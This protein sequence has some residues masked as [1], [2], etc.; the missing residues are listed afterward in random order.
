M[1][2]VPAQVP[3]KQ[4]VA[5]MQPE[6]PPV[7]TEETET[8]TETNQTDGVNT[9][10]RTRSGVG[11]ETGGSGD[12]EIRELTPPAKRT[13]K[14]KRIVLH[15]RLVS[16]GCSCGTDCAMAGYG[17]KDT[18]T[19][20]RGEGHV[21]MDYD[22]GVPNNGEPTTRLPESPSVEKQL[23]MFAALV[24]KKLDEKLGLV[25]KTTDIESLLTKVD[26][27]AADITRLR[28]SIDEVRSQNRQDK[29]DLRN[30]MK[31]YA[32]DLLRG[33]DGERERGRREPMEEVEENDIEDYPPIEEIRPRPANPRYKQT[34]VRFN[35]FET[36]TRKT[37]RAGARSEE[38]EASRIEKYN[39]ARRSVKVWPIAG[40]TKDEIT[41]N[42]TDFLHRCLGLSDAQ[43]DD[44]G[45][46]RVER[47]GLPDN[48]TVHNE[49]RIVLAS[50]TAR[51]FIFGQ[52]PK[53]ASYVTEDGKPTAGFRVD[54]P[55]Y[56]G[57]EWKL[58]DDLGFQ[59]KRENGPGTRKYIKH[60]D[61]NYGFFLEIRLPGAS[62][63]TKIS[64][65]IAQR[66]RREREREDFE[67]FS[68]ARTPRGQ[69]MTS[70][71][72]TPIGPRR[73][74]ETE[75]R[76]DDGQWRPTPRPE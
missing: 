1:V 2:V 9:K 47:T 66:M 54:V 56:L 30:E 60:D 13:V 12:E 63:W 43:V 61:Y 40:R 15:K 46:E 67:R 59:L 36:P 14:G 72:N 19:K 7:G 49:L 31:K 69:S 73:Q 34:G 10:R 8:R 5:N 35:D 55:D 62:S 75:R 23:A 71:N 20:Q 48:R 44:L 3:S 68:S 76:G 52:G 11:V 58:L 42:L 21:R 27:Q 6:I 51:D 28:F 64:P 22:E 16:G 38:Q 18:G 32:D 45:I 65:D 74:V 53:L 29:Q 37:F 24:D 33:S 17:K 4:S 50:P 39:R 25:A 70:A 26:S 57:A 41:N